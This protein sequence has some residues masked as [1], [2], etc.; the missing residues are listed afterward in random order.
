ME[1]LV[2]ILGYGGLLALYLWYDK[3]GTAT[4]FKNTVIIIGVALGFLLWGNVIGG[5]LK[6]Y[7]SET[8]H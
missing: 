3:K 7:V 1:I 4:F 5:F 2:L 6:P 8:V